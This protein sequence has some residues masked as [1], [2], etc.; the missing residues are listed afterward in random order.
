MPLEMPPE[1]I[2][3]LIIGFFFFIFAF[4][5]TVWLAVRTKE[6]GFWYSSIV[7]LMF[8]FSI[9]SIL[10][11]NPVVCVILMIFIGPYSIFIL[12]KYWKRL[13]LA[14]KELYLKGFSSQEPM[15]G[16]DYLSLFFSLKG[17][18]KLAEKQGKNPAICIYV[19]FNT[20]MLLIIEI[21]AS[22]R[23]PNIFPFPISLIYMVPAVIISTYF[24]SIYLEIDQP[25]KKETL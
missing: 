20:L 11:S 22:Y 3:I 2:T 14:Q 25:N 21:W 15:K 5:R 17:W 24:F 19:L 10:L 16:S 4:I 1:A 13:I 9:V 7:A 12:V 18:L 6:K 8:I 23:F